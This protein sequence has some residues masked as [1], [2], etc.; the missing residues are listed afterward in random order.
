MIDNLPAYIL[1]III[2]AL[3]LILYVRG[4]RI[5]EARF[6]Q[7]AEK[8]KL[9]SEGPKAQHPNVDLSIC[10]GCGS[11]ARVCPEGDVLGIMGGKA[12]I[13]NAHKCV[14]HGL[15][16]EACPVDAIAMVMAAP[17]I[18]ADLPYLSPQHETNIPNLFIA[19]ELGGLALIKN[20]VNEG[21]QCID[22]IAE[23]LHAQSPPKT[24]TNAYDVCIAGAG[25][26]GISASLRAI[27]IQQKYLT[28]E[29]GEIGGMVA[30]YPRQ[31]LVMTSPVQFPMYGKFS[32]LSLSKE[33]LLDFW[34]KISVRADFVAN[35][36][37]GLQEVCKDADGCFTIR[38]SKRQYRAYAV[39]L[40]L[41]MGGTPRKLGIKGE[42]LSKVMYRLI[43]VDAFTHRKL[44]VVG[45]GDSAVEAA[46]GLA[47]Q[48][49]N[50]VS[51]SY[52][53]DCFTRI[54]ER[55]SKR[56]EDYM[57]SGTIQVIFNS[58]PVEIKPDSVILD[59]NGTMR[60]I[61]NDYVWIFA[62]GIAPSGFL[63]KIGVQ[64]G[65]Q[66][67]SSSGESPYYSKADEI[68]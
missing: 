55:N 13:L 40:A 32:K 15:C 16:A 64:F 36:F 42:E 8:G 9:F 22:V 48:K 29:Q 5:K 51:L 67:V 11:C 39:I 24:D 54:K 49:G 37:E 68:R 61:P 10:I 1:I 50:S 62:G 19:G 66:T 45:G 34:K 14:G 47:M 18:S 65:S 56:I 41:G 28:L 4:L 58:N 38:T 2:I 35:T 31:K 26:A 46:I 33:E 3:P 53:K 59:C 43:D 25:P 27:E 12:Y 63:K 7:S 30:N 60:E 44:L 6:L 52:R 17:G 57:S 23:R 21:R 20:A